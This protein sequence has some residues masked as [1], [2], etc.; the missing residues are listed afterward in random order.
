MKTTPKTKKVKA[1]M[2]LTSD[3]E[4]INDYT[5]DLIFLTKPEPRK[6]PF[7]YSPG[8]TWKPTVVTITFTIP[9]RKKKKA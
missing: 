3:G 2:F 9:A 5:G 7:N 4:V 6:A 1:W 8:S